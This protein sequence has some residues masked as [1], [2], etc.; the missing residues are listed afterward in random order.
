MSNETNEI[1]FI[2]TFHSNCNGCHACLQT[3][4]VCLHRT[5]VSDLVSSGLG[6]PVLTFIRLECLVLGRD[7][8][9][10][11]TERGF[12]VFGLDGGANVD[13]EQ[14][15]GTH[16]SL[17]CVGVLLRLFPLTSGRVV[18]GNIVLHLLLVT[19]LVLFRLLHPLLHFLLGECLVLGGEETGAVIGLIGGTERE[20]E[21]CQ[22]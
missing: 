21:S 12:G 10:D 3:S 19:D 1:L 7:D 5:L 22:R 8:T 14:E 13:R 20:K 9:S 18:H 17:G 15:V 6:V 2:S 4:T 11:V 16:V